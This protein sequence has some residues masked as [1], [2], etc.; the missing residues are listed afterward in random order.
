MVVA[1]FSP[2]GEY[3]AL[4]KQGERVL[5][6][7]RFDKDTLQYTAV[8]KGYYHASEINDIAWS[9]VS[10]YLA[11]CSE[12]SD[13]VLWKFTNNGEDTGLD[14]VKRFLLHASSVNTVNFNARGT[15]LVTA[16][17]DT[18]VYVWDVLSGNML[19]MFRQF[20]MPV[21]SAVFSHSGQ[22]I[23]TTCLD[24]Y[25]RALFLNAPKE[26]II[27]KYTDETVPL[28]YVQM[29]PDDRY[30]LLRDVEGGLVLWDYIHKQTARRFSGPQTARTAHEV[31]ICEPNWVVSGTP[32]GV[33]VYDAKDASVLRVIDWNT[34]VLTID[35]NQQI[36]VCVG[37]SA[38]GFCFFKL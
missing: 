13:V 36:R 33:V 28:G 9:P 32:Q 26:H 19:H 27:G 30:M 37:S 6:V 15:N 11:T 14:L 4:C 18:T 23:A 3:L 8:A 16:S 35:V 10:D 20:P 31:K 17:M 22:F 7:A 25:F 29:S 38:S 34:P 21:T 1:R 2:N 24:G 5:T 12:D